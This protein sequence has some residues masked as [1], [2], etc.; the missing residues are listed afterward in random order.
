MRKITKLSV[1]AAL[2]LVMGMFLVS[3]GA[4]PPLAGDDAV[5]AWTLTGAEYAGM[6]LTAEDLS[7][8]MDEMPVFTINEDGSANFAFGGEDGAGTVTKNEDGT[9]TLSDDT[10]QT[11]NF[12]IEDS[13]L[14]LDYTAM[15]MVMNFEK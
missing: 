12:T 10:D 8:A 7:T 3:C 5:G 4:E 14:K 15:N 1:V 6:E 2:V 13:V 11:I 9:Y